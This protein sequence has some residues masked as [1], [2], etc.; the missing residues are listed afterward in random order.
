[1][2]I[3]INAIQI[4][5]DGSIVNILFG[6]GYEFFRQN[7]GAAFNIFLKFAVDYGVM[8]VLFFVILIIYMFWLVFRILG[9]NPRKPSA[10]FAIIV[11]TYS[12]V[13]AMFL[14]TILPIYFHI[15]NFA[16]ICS[17]VVISRMRLPSR[18]VLSKSTA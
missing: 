18:R 1:M 10:L 5:S 14:D 12:L 11:L 7:Y 16:F 2:G 15:M 9:K 17:M 6:H 3:W 8:F 13:F 4:F